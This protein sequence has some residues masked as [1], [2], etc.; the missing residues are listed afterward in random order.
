MWLAGWLADLF[1]SLYLRLK[2]QCQASGNKES[3]KVFFFYL[4]YVRK[5]P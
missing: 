1:L 4:S 2:A 3:F 5:I